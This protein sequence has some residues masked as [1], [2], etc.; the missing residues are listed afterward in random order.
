MTAVTVKTYSA[1]SFGA[2]AFPWLY[3]GDFSNGRI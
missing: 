1:V 3:G 2:A